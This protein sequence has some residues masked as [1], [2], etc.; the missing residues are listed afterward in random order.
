MT[1]NGIYN[2]ELRMVN[3]AKRTYVRQK[4]EVTELIGQNLK[5][6]NVVYRISAICECTHCMNVRHSSAVVISPEGKV[7]EYIIRCKACE[8]RREAQNG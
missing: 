1:P 6:G 5:A 8:T 3:E 7:T 2:S 4:S